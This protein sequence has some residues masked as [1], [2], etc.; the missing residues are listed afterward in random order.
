[1]LKARSQVFEAVRGAGVIVVMAFHIVDFLDGG[2]TLDASSHPAWLLMGIGTLGVDVFFVLSGFLVIG[3]WRAARKR[4]GR[5]RSAVADYAGRRAKRILPGY[6]LTLVVL[7]PAFA[8]HLV[9]SVDGL[10]RLVLLGSAQGYVDRWLPEE[11]GNRVYWSLTTEAHFYMLLPLMAALL[12]RLRGRWLWGACVAVTLAWRLWTPESFAESLILGR[13][14]QFAVGMAAAGLVAAFDEGRPGRLVRWLLRRDT[15]WF[16]WAVVLAVGV[17]QGA[18]E[19]GGAGRMPF[20]EWMHPIAG[21]AFAGIIVRATC[22]AREP[23]RSRSF[24]ASTGVVSYGLYLWH[25]PILETGLRATGFDRADAPAAALPVVLVV[26]ILAIVAV[27]N[28]SYRFVE[29]PFLRDRKPQPEPARRL[30]ESVPEP[31]RV[32]AG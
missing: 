18:S 25:L 10:K 6:W 2:G 7:V 24:L 30:P 20:A 3:S 12:L 23:K 11:I 32:P 8:P 21:L 4:H 26:L 16:M 17:H 15:L 22:L 9:Q 28:F 19:F 27:A 14:D 13:I 5:L 29:A 31:A 1:M